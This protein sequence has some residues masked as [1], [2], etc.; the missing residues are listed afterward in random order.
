MKIILLGSS[1]YR[2][3]QGIAE[4]LEQTGQS[5]H[6]LNYR[7]IRSR[8]L[9]SH[10]LYKRKKAFYSQ[11]R[12]NHR[13]LRAAA[14]FRPD[15]I[16][17]WGGNIILP[18]TLEE[19]RRRGIKLILWLLDT[20]DKLPQT[21]QGLS[22]YH[23][24]Y[25]LEP[26]DIKI[27]TQFNSRVAYLPPAYDPEIYHPPAAPVPR[28][29]EL[30]FVGN[31]WGRRDFLQEVAEFSSAQKIRMALVGKYWHR[32]L[33]FITSLKQCSPAIKKVVIHNGRMDPIDVNRL[34]HQT[35][36]VLNNH[37]GENLRGINPRLFDI[38]GSGAFQ[39]VDSREMLPDKFILGEEMVS[40]TSV[41]DLK[42]KITYYLGEPEKRR[43]FAA[44]AERR[45]R[46]DHTYLR[47]MEKVIKDLKELGS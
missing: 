47:R 32:G 34:Y 9:T 3:N 44:A 17:T 43:K 23:L 39:L 5:V 2:F 27:I 46:A 6:L 45:A 42:E 19:L 29:Y 10:N 1:Y 25:T 37:R 33:P 11:G 22:L 14:A 18:A 21:Q 36:I 30:A 31:H 24:V 38:A 12:V 28:K 20:I 41:K 16:L 26:N 4:A 8:K 15:A 35:R 13:L 7:D 40:Y